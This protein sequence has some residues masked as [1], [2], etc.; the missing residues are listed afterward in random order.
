MKK[1]IALLLTLT[2]VTAF[3]VTVPAAEPAAE[4]EF[5]L[6]FSDYNPEGSAIGDAEKLAMAKIEE[7]SNG[8]I[9]FEPYYSG[10][11]LE[12]MDSWSGT[13]QGLADISYYFITLS[14][15]V[16]HAGEVFTQY[17]TF[18]APADTSKMEAAYRQVLEEIPEIQEEAN[19]ANLTILDICVTCPSI[20]LFT[21]EHDINAPEDIKGMIFQAQGHY[22]D[23]L[24]TIGASG[25]AL[26]PSDWYT[27][28]ERGVVDALTFSWAGVPDF[29][30]D[31]ITNY[32][33]EFGDNGG[34]YNGGC[35]YI[36]NLD[37]WNSLPED[38]QKIV[39]EG[40]QYGND[41]LVENDAKKTQEVRKAELDAGKVVQ[42]I[43]EEDMQPWYDLAMLSVEGWI[44]DCN[45][46]GQDGQAIYDKYVEIVKSYVE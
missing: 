16:Q 42:T 40:F 4:P 45:D 15:G 10:S 14:T 37:T 22:S 12:A 46:A 19:A 23:A 6:T 38:L 11:L 24:T 41:W 8:R 28:L 29:G 13:A 7:D 17:H 32:Y 1:T 2:M 21:K 44:K 25:E 9:K 5:V 26:F 18:S 31:S 34:L 20:Y 39:K 33:L 3:A 43:P 35:A 36:M 27:S 30:F